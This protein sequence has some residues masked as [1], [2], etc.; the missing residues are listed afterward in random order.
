MHISS[1]AAQRELDVRLY[2]HIEGDDEIPFGILAQVLA[3]IQ[4]AFYLM[5]IQQESREINERARIPSDIEQRYVLRAAP[6][7]TGSYIIPAYAGNPDS[8]LSADTAIVATLDKFRRFSHALKRSQASALREIIPDGQ[9]RRRILEKFR[10]MIPKPGSGWMLEMRY[11]DDDS[12][13]FG[14]DTRQEIGQLLKKEAG[15]AVTYTV[16]GELVK[17]DFQARKLTLRYPVTQRELDCYYDPSIEELLLQKRRELIQVTGIATL[18]ELDHPKQISRVEDIRDVDISPFIL[19]EF[20]YEHRLLRFRQP[21]EL[22]PVLDESQQVLCLVY[23]ELGI[24]ICVTTRDELDIALREEI[25]FLWRNYALEDSAM[26][27]ADAVEVKKR[28]LQT[29]EEVP[30]AV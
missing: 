9:L 23:P 5:A 12:I 27:T 7:K 1:G 14:V 3:D 13:T 28:L 17:I 22:T 26:L 4:Q 2:R 16:T 21:L 24:D 19:S 11:G 25:D 10:S 8:E 15:D 29:I 30:Y 18:D 20:R 6:S